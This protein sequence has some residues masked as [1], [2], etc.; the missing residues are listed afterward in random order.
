M[1]V[2]DG[3]GVSVVV[4]VTV[5]G[6]GPALA[7]AATVVVVDGGADGVSTNEGADGVV[8]DTM[9]S[10]NEGVDGVSTA[11]VVPVDEGVDGVSTDTMVSADEGGDGVTATTMVVLDKDAD[12]VSTERTSTVVGSV[13]SLGSATASRR[14]AVEMTCKME[15]F[16]VAVGE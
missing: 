14:R 16:I 9:V 15:S 4:K 3:G 5:D 12:G 7:F 8:A 11:T 1:V 6:A 2:G 13:I 10:V